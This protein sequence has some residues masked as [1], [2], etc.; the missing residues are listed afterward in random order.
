M[1]DRVALVFA[2]LALSAPI[3]DAAAQAW[4]QRPIRA[5][6]SS[7][8]G[9]GSDTMARTMA[10]PV[11]RALGQAIVVEN[12]TGADGFLAGEACAKAAPDGYTL[13]AS[14][15]SLIIWNMVVHRNAP[16]DSLRDLAPVVQVGFFDSA[17]VVNP[18]LPV[19]S[20]QQLFDYAKANPSKV[21]WGHNGRND[22][23]FIYEEWLKL[24]R[25][26]PFFEVPYKT[27]PQAN[28]AAISGETQIVFNAIGNLA[29]HIKAG[30]LRPLGVN[31]SR[32]I[33]WLP[34]V[35]TLDELGIK[36]PLRNWIGYHYPIA[37]PRELILRMN[38]EIR[39]AME[40]PHFR[41]VM[42]RLDITPGP[43]TPEEFD[44]F[45]RKQLKEVGEL[46]V[47]IGL[48]PQ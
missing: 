35:P 23:G 42:E 15:S 28:L 46:M 24:A 37:T 6:V 16:Y 48:K 44:G 11:G 43:G 9:G 21:N 17:L 7:A 13:C 26:I 27:Q 5:I 32:R 14:N 22:T 38:S 36:L 39:R 19:S 3:G 8:A 45:V 40:T 34:D 1:K 10:E 30:K 20:L 41:G 12:R 4:P 47:E 33:A 29:A 18:S 25:G 31:S 2:G